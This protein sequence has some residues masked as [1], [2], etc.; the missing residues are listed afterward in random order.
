MKVFWCDNCM[1]SIACYDNRIEYDYCLINVKQEIP[2]ITCLRCLREL[3]KNSH[4]KQKGPQQFF[5]VIKE[6]IVAN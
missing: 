1:R 5:N 6:A 4:L 2:H 3:P